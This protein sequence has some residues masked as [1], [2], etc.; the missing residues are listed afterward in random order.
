[1]EMLIRIRGLSKSLWKHAGAIAFYAAILA[2]LVVLSLWSDWSL[3]KLL[4]SYHPSNYPVPSLKDIVVASMVVLIALALTIVAFYILRRFGLIKWDKAMGAA[5]ILPI[6]SLLIVAPAFSYRG[7][8][9]GDSWEVVDGLIE[10]ASAVGDIASMVLG[11]SIMWV[12][13]CGIWT[14]PSWLW[15]RVKRLQMYWRWGLHANRKR[16]ELWD[17][18]WRGH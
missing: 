17:M 15:V 18:Y 14:S 1:M 8:T 3:T 9:P 6:A 4:Q 13:W 2:A 10:A 5:S 11:F 7:M 16:D 12:V